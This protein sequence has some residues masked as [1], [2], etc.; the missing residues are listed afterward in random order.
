M[1][2]KKQITVWGI[3]L[4]IGVVL[5][6]FGSVFLIEDRIEKRIADKLK[7]PDILRQIAYLIR[8]SLTFD[9]K[10][11]IRTDG[12]AGQFIEKIKVEMGEADPN[13]IWIT[14]TEHL[15]TAPI[16]ECI[17]YNFD[18]TSKRV[19]KSDWLYELSSPD[20]LICSESPKKKEWIFRLEVIR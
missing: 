3:I 9:Q 7:D 18:V 6:V 11:T 8:P 14:P 1:A 15:N 20:Y 5:G 19:N 2:D 17:N 12:G 4:G 16:L 13:K 10:G